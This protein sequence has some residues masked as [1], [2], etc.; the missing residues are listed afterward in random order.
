MHYIVSIAGTQIRR[1][2][3]K[4]WFQL[5]LN[6]IFIVSVAPTLLAPD[7]AGAEGSSLWNALQSPGHVALIRHSIAPGNGDPS[8]FE[9]DDCRTQRNLSE[10]GRIQ[11]KLIGERFRSNGI[12]R[13]RTLSSQWCRCRETAE[14][15]DLGT[16]EDLPILNSFFQSFMD[17]DRQTQELVDWLLSQTL[18]EPL[19]LVTHQVNITALTNVYPSSGEIVVIHRSDKGKISVVGSLNI[20]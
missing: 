20:D 19:L 13:A 9:L 11:A 18:K 14:L 3:T 8:A 7:S 15:L 6:F 10:E 12:A 2:K 5:P 16:V 1:F 4:L 17:R